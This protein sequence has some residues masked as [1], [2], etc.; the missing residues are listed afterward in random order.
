MSIA[1]LKKA[2]GPMPDVKTATDLEL[3]E[4]ALNKW[5]VIAR[6]SNFG[7]FVINGDGYVLGDHT[8]RGVYHVDASTCSLCRQHSKN[9]CQTCPFA[10]L[11]N[12]VRCFDAARREKLSPYERWLDDHDPRPMVKQLKRL[13]ASLKDKTAQSTKVPSGYKLVDPSLA[14]IDITED[15]LRSMW[16][17]HNSTS[18]A[19]GL[20]KSVCALIESIAHLRGFDTSEWEWKN[21]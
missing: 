10:Q 13:V 14:Y 7:V 16:Q 18:G 15:Q 12:G 6:R 20:C 3:A 2:I 1:E 19:Q 9:N 8:T 5:E 11:R 21:C 17:A 4:H